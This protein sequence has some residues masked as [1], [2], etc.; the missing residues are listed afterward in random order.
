MIMTQ[1]FE[2]IRGFLFQIMIS[3]LIK[4]RANY[5]LSTKYF[6]G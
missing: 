2:L 5:L 6:F 1:V 3:F 4:V